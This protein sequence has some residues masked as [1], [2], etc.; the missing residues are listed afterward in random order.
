MSA[1]TEARAGGVVAVDLEGP[2]IDAGDITLVA[3][4]GPRESDLLPVAVAV[5]VDPIAT[6]ARWGT[7]PLSRPDDNSR[8]VCKPHL[9][10]RE[11]CSCS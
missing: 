8:R 7:R 2:G 1:F 9:P 3:S 4:G 5:E 6:S 10:D 11:G